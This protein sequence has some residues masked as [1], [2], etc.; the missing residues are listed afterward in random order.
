MTGWMYD[1]AASG[2]R[3]RMFLRGSEAVVYL[4]DFSCHVAPLPSRAVSSHGAL[5]R[6]RAR[7]LLSA[8]V[9]CLVC[10]LWLA[11]RGVR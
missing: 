9:Q 5:V 3:L 11:V 1:A 2:P 8:K 7:S 4:G 10:L 6:F